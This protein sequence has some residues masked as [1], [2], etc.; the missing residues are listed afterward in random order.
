VSENDLE[1]SAAFLRAPPH[2]DVIQL[3]PNMISVNPFTVQDGRIQSTST[4]EHAPVS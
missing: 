1:T 2:G 3:A 4:G